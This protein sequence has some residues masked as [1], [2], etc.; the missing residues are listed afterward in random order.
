MTDDDTHCQLCTERSAAGH[1]LDVSD[2]VID[3][4][5]R[6]M[7]KHG[8][9]GSDVV[10]L[11]SAAHEALEPIREQCAQ[12]KAYYPSNNGAFNEGVHYAVSTIARF[13]HVASDR[14]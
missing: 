9:H 2:P 8:A 10:D 3:A 11:V 7:A 6:A 1:H 13:L 12:L 4:V 14:T 5:N